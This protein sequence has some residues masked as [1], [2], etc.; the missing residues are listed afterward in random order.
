MPAFDSDGNE[1]KPV[2][3]LE[4]LCEVGGQFDET[5][6]TISVYSEK[7]DRHKVT[8]L[9]SVQPTSA[10]NPGERHSFGNRGGTRVV[11]WGKWYLST[12]SDYRP[13]SDKI[14]ELLDLCTNDLEAWG[15]L[16]DEYDVWM[17]V[18]GYL[19]NWNRNMNL[20][21]EILRLLADRRLALQVDVYFQD[22]K[23]DKKE[24][25]NAMNTDK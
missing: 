5:S 6:A 18:V 17:H 25:N 8:T 10:W 23:E 24:S 21:S 3:K 7:L 1:I 16:A 19:R 22:D 13:I 14:R 2:G 12:E 20:P 11:K 4:H 9:L 15:K